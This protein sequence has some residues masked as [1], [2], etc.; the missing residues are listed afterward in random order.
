[1][2][3]RTDSTFHRPGDPQGLP[4]DPFLAPVSVPPP[5]VPPAPPGPPAPARPPAPSLLAEPAE[6]VEPELDSEQTIPLALPSRVEEEPRAAGLPWSGPRSAYL[7]ETW[8]EDGPDPIDPSA[9]DYYDPPTDEFPP[10]TGYAMPIYY[11]PGASQAPAEVH[12]PVA[13]QP[14]VATSASTVA[15]LSVVFAP[16][17]IGSAV[18]VALGVAAR[19]H[20]PSGVALSL[21]GFSGPLPAKVWL[22][23]GALLLAFVQLGSAFAMASKGAARSSRLAGLHRWSGRVAFLLTVPIAVHC[24]YALGYQTLTF[25]SAIHSLAG[26]FF[27]GAFTAKM[28]IL[29]RRGVPGWVLPAVGGAVFAAL[30]VLWLTSSLWFFG[31]YGIRF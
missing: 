11:P 27:F 31:T 30:V 9:A 14:P 2:Q 26:C 17:A 8:T 12:P 23:T 25:R 29:P 18:A 7:D 19:M 5:P 15:G 1:M 13:V 6:P 21:V 28:L 10:V 16:I 24:L 22:T 3:T 4:P 20:E